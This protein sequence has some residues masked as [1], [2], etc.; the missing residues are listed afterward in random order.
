MKFGKV[1]YVFLSSIHSDYYSGFP[2]FYLSSR[3]AT[4]D[5][6]LF[7]IGVFGPKSLKQTLLN[8]ISF[9]GGLRNIEVFEYGS[10]NRYLTEQG[11]LNFIEKPYILPGKPN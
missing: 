7:K 5:L 6:A 1:R 11:N 2:G 8:S 4:N 9:I 3:E 10:L